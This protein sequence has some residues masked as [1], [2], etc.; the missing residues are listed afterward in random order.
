MDL[1]TLDS[2]RREQ[3]ALR[4]ELARLRGRLKLQLFLEFAVDAAGV[5]AA[6]GTVLVLL[7]WM[8]R[9]GLVARTILLVL[10]LAGTI[11]FLATRAIR[12]RRSAGLDD[13][14]LAMTLDRHRP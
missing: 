14:S 13:L 10:S 1:P 9:L 5:L 2:L 12:R 3:Q 6:R 4:A 11:G 7:D 8:F